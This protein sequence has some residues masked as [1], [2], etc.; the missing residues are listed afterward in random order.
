MLTRSDRVRRTAPDWDLWQK[1]Y[2]Q[3]QQAY[4][5]KRLLAIKYL[6]LGKSR[7][8]VTQLLGCTYVT[9]TKWIDNFLEGGRLETN[10][11]NYS[12]SPISPQSRA[13]TGTQKNAVVTKAYRLRHR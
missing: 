10:R 3:H 12:P 11:T 7:P 6:W 5:R 8:E 9:L 1:L 13:T 4:I 2:Y